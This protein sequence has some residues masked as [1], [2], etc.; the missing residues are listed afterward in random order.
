MVELPYSRLGI[1]CQK[2]ART[3]ALNALPLP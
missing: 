1:S 3:F 2:S